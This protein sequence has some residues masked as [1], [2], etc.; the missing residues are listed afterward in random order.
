MDSDYFLKCKMD[1]I[2]GNAKT[3]EEKRQALIEYCLID[4]DDVFESEE[5]M[6]DKA[7]DFLVEDETLMGKEP[8][9][10]Y[11]GTSE[12]DYHEDW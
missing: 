2:L 4:D 6:I 3:F 12:Y 5:E 7:M 11:G 9:Y 1:E 10:D 8:E